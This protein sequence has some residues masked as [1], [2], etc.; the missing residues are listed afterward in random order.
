M[1]KLKRGYLPVALLVLITL[2]VT[3]CGGGGGSA[4]GGDDDGPIV[5]GSTFTLSGPVA[6]AGQMAFEGAELAV[7]YVN[8]E[9]GGI[10]GR[11]VE[12][13]Y[14]DDEFDES[15]ILLLRNHVTCTIFQMKLVLL[16]AH[17]RLYKSTSRGNAS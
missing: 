17:L 15:K 13:K 6:H 7:K 3:A 11:P 16:L 14:Y 5:I 8:E 12:L 10:N 2:T 9:L 1:R 4:G